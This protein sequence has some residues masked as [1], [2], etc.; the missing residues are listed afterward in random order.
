MDMKKD[1]AP[2]G[3]DCDGSP[4]V[5]VL[6]IDDDMDLNRTLAR[7]IRVKLGYEA[8]SSF[9][10]EDARRRIEE[11]FFDV[12][13][14]DVRMPDGNGIQA[15]PAFRDSHC[16]PEIIVLT[17]DPEQFGAKQAL[18][19]GARDYLIKPFDIAEML[20]PLERA[21][22]FRNEKRNAPDP[23][24]LDL[25]GIVATG[26]S[27]ESCLEVLACAAKSCANVL[28]AGETGTG[29]ELLA[30]AIHRNSDRA[31]GKFAVVDCSTI[32]ETL[33]ENLL[34]GHEKGSFTGADTKTEGMVM[35]AR[36]GT[37]FLDEVG[38]LPLSVQAKFLRLIEERRFRRVGGDKEIHCDFR[39]VAVTNKNLSEMVDNGLFR[40]DLLHRLQGFLIKIP[41]LKDRK[42]DIIPIAEYHLDRLCKEYG[43]EKK[44]VSDSFIGK[45]ISY[46]WPGNVRELVGALRS[47]IEAARDLPTLYPRH[48][49]VT[50]RVETAQ[51]SIEE[52]APSAEEA[53]CEDDEG[54]LAT[55][56]KDARSEK[57]AEM[58]KTYISKLMTATDN[59]VKKAMEISGLSRSRFYGLLEQYKIK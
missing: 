49:P 27:M 3:G 34:F 53:P 29:K 15:L 44:A 41:L 51:A 46:S 35:D 43:M 1:A 16:R 7:V 24:E 4:P 36:D 9:H 10:L 33:S 5:K 54:E 28:I 11:D 14:L 6:I 19:W 25:A 2:I 30:R 21:L 55:P 40:S 20:G 38:D 22:E 39:L 48:L 32:P 12:V 45:L 42:E 50:I 57:V 31:A 13:F 47:A 56:W 18:L 37:L 58:E 59:D 8:V 26:F 52:T 17:G 23:E